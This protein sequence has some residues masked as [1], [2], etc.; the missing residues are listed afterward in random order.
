MGMLPFRPSSDISVSPAAFNNPAI[1]GLL[2]SAPEALCNCYVWPTRHL[3]VLILSFNHIRRSADALQCLFHI[4]WSA[5]K[6][7]V[8]CFGLI[9]LP[10]MSFLRGCGRWKRTRE[11]ASS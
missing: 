8:K 7:V 5:V 4:F 9:C 3:T 6:C 10:W 11:V 1:N 2:D